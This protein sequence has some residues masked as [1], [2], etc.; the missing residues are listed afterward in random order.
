M[1]ISEVSLLR[2]ANGHGERA[3]GTARERKKGPSRR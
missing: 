2:K 1:R 3:T